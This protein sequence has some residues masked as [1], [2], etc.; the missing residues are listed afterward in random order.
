[1]RALPF[2]HQRL[3]PPRPRRHAKPERRSSAKRSAD[4]M[5]FRRFQARRGEKRR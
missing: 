5:L 2:A 4:F 1:L 3:P